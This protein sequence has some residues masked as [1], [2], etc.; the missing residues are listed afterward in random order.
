M[1][2]AVLAAGLIGAVIADS[3]AATEPTTQSV[4]PDAA[5]ADVARA[6]VDTFLAWATADPAVSDAVRTTLREA[7]AR[8]R[9]EADPS[10]FLAEALALVSPEY[11][12]ALEAIDTGRYEDAERLLGPLVAADSRYVGVHAASMLAR[13]L[14]EQDKTD[15]A[16][17]LLEA[18]YLREREVKQY[19][20]EAPEMALLR[21]HCLVQSLKQARAA[22]ILQRF[23][24]EYPDASERLR[25]TAKQI[26]QELQQRR[27]GGLGDVADLMGYAGRQLNAGLFDRP[28]TEA[29]TRAIELLDALIEATEAQEQQAAAQQSVPDGQQQDSSNRAAEAP[30]KPAEQSTLPQGAR[31][32]GPLRP[33]PVARPGE[34]WGAMPARQR[35]QI[36]Q[37][38]RENYP[39]RYRDLV[40]QYYRQLGRE[41]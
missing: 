13:A 23:E 20:F 2:I 27:A 26:L 1:R 3:A 5:H 8:R 39:S 7:W 9:D 19:S 37:S 4:P 38:L 31:D 12:K 10:G 15:A 16:L 36:L 6:K 24:Q 35:E 34:A 17:A 28:V 40:E 29:Q 25:L 33:S 30:S 21:A 22:A 32:G 14:V 11:R 18:W 41:E